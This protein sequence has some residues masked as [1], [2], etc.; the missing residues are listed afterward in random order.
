V[1]SFSSTSSSPF[2]LA[3]PACLVLS[4]PGDFTRAYASAAVAA[5]RSQQLKPKVQQCAQGS[6]SPASLL[7]L[8]CEAGEAGET[9]EIAGKSD[10]GGFES[11]VEAGWGGEV[12]LLPSLPKPGGGVCANAHVAVPGAGGREEYKRGSRGRPDVQWAGEEEDGGGKGGNSEGNGSG[13]AEEGRTSRPWSPC[14][15][16]V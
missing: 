13:G 6:C 12:S 9:A 5:A 11:G 7:E 16:L 8:G 15:F 10:S 2:A 4:A 14:Q 3:E 1:R